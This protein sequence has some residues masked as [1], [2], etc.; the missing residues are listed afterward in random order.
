MPGVSVPVSL[1]GAK[2]PLGFRQFQ[3]IELGRW[4]GTGSPEAIDDLLEAIARTGGAVTRRAARTARKAAEPQ[5]APVG[6]RAP[7]HQHEWRA[8]TG[9]FQRRNH[10]GHHHR[11]VEG[12]RAVDRRAQHGVLVQGPDGR[13]EGS[14]ENARSHLRPRRQRPQ[15]RQPGPNHGAADR[16]RRWGS[17]WA[18]R[19]DRDLDDIFAIQDEISK[20]IVDAL[21]IKLLPEEK[22]AIEQRG[23]NN[24]DAY[25]LYLMARQQWVSGNFGDPKRDE[26]IVRVC[27]QVT[28]LDP[29][30]A[31]A[32]ALM[33]LAQAEL[34]FVHGKDE[35]AL[36]AADRALELNSA[37]PEAHCIKARYLE[38]E[39]RA[40]EAE[41]QIRI[42]APAQSGFVGGQPRSGANA[43]P[44]WPHSQAAEYFGKAASVMET[45]WHNP[46]MLITCCRSTGDKERMVDAAKMTLERSE[47]AVA[48]D[49]TSGQALASGANALMILGDTER[50]RDWSRR[51]L[52]LDPD[53]LIMSYNLACALRPNRW[54][55]RRCDQRASKLLRGHADRAEHPSP[56][57]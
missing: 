50:A 29:N 20:A 39:G 41:N 22:K 26:A 32:W 57:V 9:V 4:D 47:R 1:A 40:D 7:L 6:L 42:G 17:R 12:L 15:S 23:T 33:A 28:G 2:P 44:A 43:V 31:E 46:L 11:P 48:K 36:P 3:T 27:K 55:N 30:Y 35:N 51:A 16:R 24:V 53:N 38:E 21:K 56:R 52:L 14:R 45:D 10:R 18:D 5:K 19:Y 25:N 54:R 13:R 37:L 8:R 49:P 34:R